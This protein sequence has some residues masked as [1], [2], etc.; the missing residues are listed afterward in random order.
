MQRTP[1]IELHGYHVFQ[2]SAWIL[3]EGEDAHDF[4]QSQFSN[5]LKGLQ[6]GDVRYGLWLDLKGK[7]QGDSQ[8]LRTDAEAFFLFSYFTSEEFLLNKLSQFIIADDV[9][10]TGMATKMAGVSLLGGSFATLKSIA[11]DMPDAGRFCIGDLDMIVLP[12]RRGNSVSLEILLKSGDLDSFLT[13]LKEKGSLSIISASE[14]EAYRI[15]SRLP[16][17]PQDI[18]PSELPQEGGLEMDGISFTKGCYLGQEV[19]SRL[20]SMGQVRRSLHL[21]S[22][23]ASVESGTTIFSNQKKVGLVKSVLGY[24]GKW[25]ALALLPVAL[26][27]NLFLSAGENENCPV[28]KVLT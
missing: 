7:V 21:V 5:D 20:H 22:L 8:I 15:F 28:V 25:F 19:M 24:K 1:E 3:V 26:A 18:G 10:L 23:S 9:E 14:M 12:G 16:S 27:E 11:G 6:I 17:V 4:L 2:P 13:L